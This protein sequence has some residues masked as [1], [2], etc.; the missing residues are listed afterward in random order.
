LDAALAERP[1]LLGDAFSIADLN[2]ASVLSLA[3]IVSFDL[4]GFP[5]VKRWFD[6]S[7]SR[8]AFARAL[9]S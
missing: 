1:H 7:L 3:N 9:Q 6:S 2:V 8:P 4:A 5:N